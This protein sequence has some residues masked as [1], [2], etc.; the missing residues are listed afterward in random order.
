MLQ[1]LIDT[2]VRLTHGSRG[3]IFLRRDDVLVARAFHSNVPAE[4]RAYLTA[5][6]WRL[7]GDSHMARAARERV[8]VHVAD[9]S[10]S[11]IESDKQVQKRASFGAGLWT[12]LLREGE[13]IGVFGV[14][15]DEPIAFT[16]RKSSSSRPSPT[17]P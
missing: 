3:T 1:T 9:L 10:Q 11:Q 16:D 6:P 17:R 13:L 7:D 15:R 8:V 4:L 5:T 2:A 12:P 14:P